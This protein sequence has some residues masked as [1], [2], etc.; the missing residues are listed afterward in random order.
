MNTEK[1]IGLITSLLTI[2]ETENKPFKY[3]QVI[4]ELFIAENKEFIILD[5]CDKPV[6]SF[7]NENGGI[8]MVAAK[9]QPNKKRNDD[10]TED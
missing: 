7:I 9:Q 5:H 1:L 10:V 3:N 8:S 6:I 2:A 4:E